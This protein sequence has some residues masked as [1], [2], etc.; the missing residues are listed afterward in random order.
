M[1]KTEFEL[2]AK[3]HLQIVEF[4]GE[5]KSFDKRLRLA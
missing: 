3:C 5:K 4:D 2:F 1:A